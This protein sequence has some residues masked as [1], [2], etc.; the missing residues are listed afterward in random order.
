MCPDRDAILN[1]CATIYYEE[2]LYMNCLSNLNQVASINAQTY[3]NLALTYLHL[4]EHY[5]ANQ[6]IY[7]AYGE[8]QNDSLIRWNKEIF[9]WIYG[10]G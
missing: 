8:D 6:A 2:K 5:M 9:D 3:N 4:G 1:N 7:K 10:M